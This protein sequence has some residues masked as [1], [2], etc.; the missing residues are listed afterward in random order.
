MPADRGEAWINMAQRRR[1]RAEQAVYLQRMGIT[2]WHPRRAG[3]VPAAPAA[4]DKPGSATV[5]EEATGVPPGAEPVAA[6]PAPTGVPAQWE[7][8]QQ[9]VAGC[10][11]CGLCDS[12]TQTVFGVGSRSA[13][14]MVIGEAPGAEEDR[15]GEPFVGRAGKL[16]D[17]MLAALG[18]QREQVFIAN[19][20][21][22]RPPNNRDPLADEVASCIP[23]LREQMRLLRPK[24]ILCVGRVAAQNLLQQEQPLR[25]LRARDHLFDTGDIT[26]PVIVS[27][28]PAYLLR[29]P[30]EKSKA[31]QDL[32]RLRPLLGG[33]S[34]P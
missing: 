21:K 11:L 3:A 22:C 25:A 33:E 30:A 12:R 31:W 34:R 18:L 7:A 10:K 19:I 24:V 17:A 14:L 8:L 32:K 1:S 16:L 15:R 23:Y 5:A 26:I 4:E 28:H 27:Y 6:A 13:D 20:L 29:S 9:T 2:A